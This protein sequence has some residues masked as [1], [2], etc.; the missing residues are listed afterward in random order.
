MMEAC[1]DVSHGLVLLFGIGTVAGV[2]SLK[3]LD[4]KRPIREA[5]TSVACK[6][7]C[8]LKPAPVP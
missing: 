2:D 6:L 7:S 3:A 1:V 5:R 8:S 4:P